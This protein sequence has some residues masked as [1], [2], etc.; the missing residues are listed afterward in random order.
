MKRKFSANK[1]FCSISL[2]VV[3]LCIVVYGSRFFYYYSKNKETASTGVTTLVK[4]IKDKNKENKNFG[5]ISGSY[6]FVNDA[7]NNYVKYSN[8]TWRIVK[9]NSDNTILLVANESVSNLAFGENKKSFKESY[10]YEWLN[11]TEVDN[12]GIF[13]RNLSEVKGTLVKQKLCKDKVNSLKKITCNKKDKDIYVGLLSIE[14]YINVGAD[15]SYL[16]NNSSFYLSNL[17]KENRVWF[18]SDGKLSSSDG[19]DLY[20]IRPTIL[21]RDGLNYISGDGS[22]ASP[23]ILTDKNNLFGS[24]VT[25]GEDKWQIYDV[26]NEEVKMSLVGYV[27]N[28]DNT[29][30][31]RDYST[32]GY[33]YDIKEYNTLP[34]YLN[35][36]YLTVRINYGNILDECSW[37][38]GYYGPENG[39]DYKALYNSMVNAK[40]GLLS[41][42]DINL[43]KELNRYYMMSGYAENSN[44]VYYR[45][46]DG[47]LTTSISDEDNKI[48]PAICINSSKLKL[49]EDGTYGV[50]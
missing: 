4:T 5:A 32:L 9:I 20:G 7:D 15:K 39:Y 43:N 21:V 18:V 1:T 28:Y 19:T 2:L 14:D 44:L 38:N 45:N 35:N 10:I 13:E 48:V 12:T 46:E 8:I 11:K 29:P 36:R 24:Y 6:Y 41:V 30:F 17:N 25:L 26:N 49:N 3:F 50:E 42:P 22:E 40:V 37:N 47:Q 27:M 23:Y 34:Y 31:E 16:N 33:K